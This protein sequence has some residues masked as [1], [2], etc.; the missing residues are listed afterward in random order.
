MDGHITWSAHVAADDLY[1]TLPETLRAFM[2][3]DTLHAT[4]IMVVD[5]AP[6]GQKRPE[7]GNP[8][9]QW[10]RNPRPKSAGASHNQALGLAMAHV[11]DD[12]ATYAVLI[13]SPD[14]IVSEDLINKLTGSFLNDSQMAAIGPRMRLAH[15]TGSLD[16][17]R[18][19]IE[20]TE[21]P[22]E[23]GFGRGWFGR[24]KNP[25]GVS[26]LCFAVRL[27][28]LRALSSSGPWFQE[29]GDWARAVSGL[30]RRL[31]TAGY[32]IVEAPY[33]TAWRLAA[34]REA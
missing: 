7:F 30:F 29:E 15:I 31:Q 18:H 22:D 10:L 4:R 16:G 27:S 12:P 26:P 14:V 5:N 34:R 33:A 19:D 17:E 9:L 23:T 32:S 20:Y 24:Q 8:E 13:L 21:T 1:G 25:F 11:S 6:V 3:R 2:S 28:A